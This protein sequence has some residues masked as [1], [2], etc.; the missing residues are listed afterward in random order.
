[1]AYV[2]VFNKVITECQVFYDLSIPWQR[3]EYDDYADFHLL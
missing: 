3:M 2:I 1:M